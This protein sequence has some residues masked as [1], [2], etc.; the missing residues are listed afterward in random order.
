V[1]VAVL[2]TGNVGR[3]IGTALVHHGHDVCLGSRTADNAAASEWAAHHQG[4]RAT[5]GTFADAA[6]FGE[7]VVNCTSGQATLDVLRAAGA[8]HLNGKVLIDVSNP[9]DFSNGFPPSL[10]VANTDSLGEQ[11]QRAFPD[12][13]VVKTL[14]T[15]TAAV[16][17]DPQSLSEPTDMFLAGEDPSAKDVARGLLEQLGWAPERIRDLGGIDAARGMEAWVLLWIRL[18]GTLGGPVFNIRLVGTD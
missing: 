3:T 6:A 13:R 18:M 4:G 2:G 15:L 16:M 11:I 12:T 14:N 1:H 10:T 8:E 9:L 17:V 5:H 7:I